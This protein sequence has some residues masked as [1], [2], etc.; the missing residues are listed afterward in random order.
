M[1]FQLTSVFRNGFDNATF[2][3]DEID[4]AEQFSGFL[5]EFLKV[6]SEL[7]HKKFYVTGES[8]GNKSSSEDGK[9]TNDIF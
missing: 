5:V 1:S 8:Y 4:L 2:L 9:Q 6:F 7:K 3:R